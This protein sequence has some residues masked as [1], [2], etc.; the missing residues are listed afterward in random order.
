MVFLVSRSLDQC[1]SCTDLFVNVTLCHVFGVMMLERLNRAIKIAAISST[2]KNCAT[3]MIQASQKRSLSQS[4]QLMLS[5][6]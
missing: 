4:L 2:R 1:S 6:L 3:Q 5:A